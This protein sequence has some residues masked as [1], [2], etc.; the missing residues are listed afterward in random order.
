MIDFVRKRRF[1]PQRE[2]SGMRRK[3]TITRKVEFQ[4]VVF[5]TRQDLFFEIAQ[6]EE[7]QEGSKNTSPSRDNFQGK[8]SKNCVA[9]VVYTIDD[10]AEIPMAINVGVM[11]NTFNGMFGSRAMENMIEIKALERMNPHV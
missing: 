8:N 1:K 11:E 2:R 7:G 10:H 5:V 6:K 4:S 9:S 3:H